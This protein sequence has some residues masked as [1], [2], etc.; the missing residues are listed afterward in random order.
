[1][2]EK[3]TIQNLDWLT[4]EYEDAKSTLEKGE[5]ELASILERE[6]E[7]KIF[8]TL[9]KSSL[10][11]EYNI[12]A[13]R[14][15]AH[16]LSQGFKEEH[17]RLYKPV[18][19]ESLRGRVKVLEIALEMVKA[20]DRDAVSFLENKKTEALLRLASAHITQRARRPPSKV[21]EELIHYL[22]G[23]RDTMPE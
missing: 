13:N 22:L 12:K 15:L 5:R 18:N 6:D 8:A 3:K 9:M 4:S 1:M 20:G 21:R 10:Q 7:E 16:R 14:D 11:D 2:G 17:R 19:I 23:R